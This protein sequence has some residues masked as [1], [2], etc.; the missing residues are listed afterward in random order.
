MRVD[1]DQKNLPGQG[2]LPP[3]FSLYLDL[4]RFLA[5]VAV[6]VSH[7]LTGGLIPP[8]AAPYIPELGREAVIVFFVL[9]GFV[10]KYAADQKHAG[11]QDYVVARCARIY[12]VAL[13]VLLA[14]FLIAALVLSFSNVTVSTGYQVAKAYIYIPF[15]LMFAGEFW[16][17]GETP[18]WLIPYWSLSYEVWYYVLFG[19]AYYLSGIRRTLLLGGV[20]LLVGFKLWLLFPV[21]LSGAWLYGWSKS[22]PIPYR[23]ARAGWVVS[24]VALCVFKITDADHYLRALGGELWP[25]AGLKLGSADRFLSDYLVCAIILTNFVCARNLGFSALRM[26]MGPVRAL[27]A[28]TFTL[29]LVH[30]LVLMAW[31]GFYPHQPAGM[32]DLSLLLVSVATVTYLAGFVTERRKGAFERFFRGLY[33]RAVRAWSAGV[34]VFGR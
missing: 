21:W 10:I 18:P 14:S 25:I 17:L 20:V 8:G 28:Y 29:Y 31:K 1:A 6:V 19:I 15:H 3:D 12:S 9:S 26:S 4:V 32:A 33:D 5:A 7:L 11:L 24:I 27:S 13:P 2:Q 30:N 34:A 16:N 22:H 23:W